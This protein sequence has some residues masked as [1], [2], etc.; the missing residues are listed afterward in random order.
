MA[1]HHEEGEVLGK[2]KR[3][4]VSCSRGILPTFLTPGAFSQ[5]LLTAASCCL[6]LRGSV[7]AAP[8]TNR[9]KV[10]WDRAGAAVPA[11]L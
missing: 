9:T 4:D 7:N 1:G 5:R 8:A 3:W 11:E 10:P 2:H 6:A